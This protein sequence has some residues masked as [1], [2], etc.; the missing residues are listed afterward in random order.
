MT[1]TRCGEAKPKAAQPT[2]PDE[3]PYGAFDNRFQDGWNACRK[4]MLEGQPGYVQVPVELLRE[5]AAILN[6]EREMRF[7]IVDELD[8]FASMLAA[9]PKVNEQ[10]DKEMP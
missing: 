4:A 1:K 8:G 7:P 3:M 5:A 9:A 2:V 6:G 10:A